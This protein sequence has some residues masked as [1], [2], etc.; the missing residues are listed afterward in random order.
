[1]SVEVEYTVYLTGRTYTGDR[2]ELERKGYTVI[3]DSYYGSGLYLKK[4]ESGSMVYKNLTDF[5]GSF[6]EDVRFNY[7]SDYFLDEVEICINKIK[8]N[9]NFNE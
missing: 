7:K 8:M 1:M 3:P 4:K 5:I 6:E 9:I 2:K